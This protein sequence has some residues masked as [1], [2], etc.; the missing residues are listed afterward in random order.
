VKK[1]NCLAYA[2]IIAIA[3]ITN[4]PNYNSYRKGWKIHPVFH[5][6]HATTGINL[7]NGGGIP[8]L[9]EIQDH[10]RQYKIVYTGLNCDSIMY[11][12]H[13][14]TADRINLYDDAAR[15]CDRLTGAMAKQFV[16]KACDNGC[17]RNITHTSKDK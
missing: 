2:L 9:E 1:R 14:E 16:C 5:Y 3:K 7:D 10:F 15:H 13:V 12:G 8:E 6:L 17:R 11:E 4:D